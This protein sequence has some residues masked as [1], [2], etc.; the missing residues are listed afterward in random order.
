MPKQ[1]FFTGLDI[2]TSEIKAA[3]ARLSPSNNEIEIVASASEP[4]FG[5][6]KGVVVDKEKVSTLIAS[7]LSKLEDEI[8]ANISEVFVNLNGSH[9][10]SMTSQGA[11]AVS[12]ADGVISKEDVTR[13][14]EAAKTFPLFQ[15]RKILRVFPQE[16]KVDGQEG[17]EEPVEM[18][19]VRLETQILVIGYFAPY[20]DNL[21][22]A[23]L[24][25]D[26]Q[27]GHVMTNSLASAKAILLPQEKEL[28]VLAIDIG[29]GTTNFAVFKEKILLKVGVV[30]VGSLNITKD[31]AMGLKTDIETAEAI[32]LNF[33]QCFL[34][35]KKKIKVEE[36][37]SG[38]EISFSQASLGKIIDARAKEIFKLVKKE[39]KDF[40]LTE[41]V[42]GVVLT[43]GGSKLPQI[44][45]VAKKEL[46]L[47]TRLGVCSAILL[48]DKDPSLSTLCGLILEARDCFQDNVSFVN[49]I[50]NY[51]KEMLKEL[52]P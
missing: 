26:Y 27:I 15:N 39:L 44:D 30:P 3:V 47:V 13:V 36:N 20:F 2:G 49:G 50:I 45:K 52:I 40:P 6:R 17:I 34:S 1:I 22:E 28:G 18:K 31:I 19:G 16:F 48:E 4:C 10:F 41:L 46:G 37:R 32:K 38:E 35:G 29:A 25:A 5:V 21:T 11:V 7:V 9:I 12:R 8:G 23:V 51:V 43:G 24:G 14:I 42:G 33:G